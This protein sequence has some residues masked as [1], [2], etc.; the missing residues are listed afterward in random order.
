MF[1]KHSSNVSN[2]PYPAIR[3][4]YRVGDY[5]DSDGVAG[6]V[7]KVTDNGQ[8][9]I[10]MSGQIYYDQTWCTMRN[11]GIEGDGFLTG[12]SSEDDGWENFMVIK[13]I[14]KNTSLTWDNFPA[15]S[16]CLALGEGWYIPAYNEYYLMF[17]LLDDNDIQRDTR[18]IQKGILKVNDYL[19]EMG[20]PKTWL[21]YE[22][23]S[24]T[25]AD[26]LHFYEWGSYKRGK[27]A[28]N[29]KNTGIFCFRAFHKF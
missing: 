23:M 15:F 11:Y 14:I 12:A 4:T 18:S 13:E 6:V 16:R 22:Y 3:Q 2:Y 27:R 26:K 19:Q 28:I 1:A 24:S 20:I 9:G 8:H 5:F 7:I 25:E 21:G 29:K 17:N 10:I